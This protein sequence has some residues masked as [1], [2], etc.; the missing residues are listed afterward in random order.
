MC[1]VAGQDFNK[2]FLTYISFIYFSSKFSGFFCQNIW[3]FFFNF[4]RFWRKQKQNCTY[5][6]L[7]E[8]HVRK[9]RWTYTYNTN[10][11]LYDRSPRPPAW[12]I[13]SPLPSM[14]SLFY[15]FPLSSINSLFF[16]LPRS[17]I[18]SLLLFP[19][20]S[21]SAHFHGNP[22]PSIP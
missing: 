19:L 15:G 11:K 20:T 18:Y 16:S 13:S 4:F 3:N 5:L 14:D 22:L 8:L 12:I 2:F 9:K 1:L 10:N 6:F 17:S 7:S 21:S